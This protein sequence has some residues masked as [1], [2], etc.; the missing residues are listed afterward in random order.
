MS[1][2]I[3]LTLSKALTSGDKDLLWNHWGLTQEPFPSL[4]PADNKAVWVAPLQNSMGLL[5]TIT[6]SG[7]PL[8]KFAL[9]AAVHL[10]YGMVKCW[11]ALQLF[12]FLAEHQE[13]H[14]QM[15]SFF[16]YTQSKSFLNAGIITR[17]Q[18]WDLCVITPNNL[19]CPWCCRGVV[20]LP[21]VLWKARPCSLSSP[22]KVSVAEIA[23]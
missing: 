19:C 4:A 8:R 17:K 22:A 15:S 13:A 5:W 14:I 2:W 23:R 1:H 3:W 10:G 20:W 12:L 11:G 21:S 18:K 9:I 16:P 7:L 6:H